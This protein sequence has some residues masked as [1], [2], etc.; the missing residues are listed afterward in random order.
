MEHNIWCPSLPWH[1]NSLALTHWPSLY[2][3]VGQFSRK[4]HTSFT[5]PSAHTHRQQ[6]AL[7]NG[8]I[9]PVSLVRHYMHKVTLGVLLLLED[10][11][12]LFFSHNLSS[13]AFNADTAVPGLMEQQLR[14]GPLSEPNDLVAF[15]RP[16]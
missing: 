16:S 3:W 1:T 5:V 2:T 10:S 14:D 11:V 7:A 6:R 4:M 12:D 15:C 13:G 8:A 9:A